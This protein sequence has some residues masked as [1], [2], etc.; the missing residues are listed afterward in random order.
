[1]NRMDDIGTDFLRETLRWLRF[2]KSL[3]DGAMAQ[4]ADEM[5]HAQPGGESNSIALIVK[6]LSGNMV[7]RWTDFL[8]A[9]GEK[10]DRNRDAEFEDDDASRTDVL[11]RWERGWASILGALEA[12]SSDDLHRTVTIRSE[13]VGVINAIQRQVTHVSYHVGQI[14]YL[15]KMLKG[16]G[17]KSLSIAR[18]QSEAYIEKMR[19]EHSGS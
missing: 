6:H 5:L 16:D 10:P 11:A 7:S 13:Q 2:E 17:W 9:D 3:G 14:V 1:M 8:T 4:I 19:R 15:S 18:G 12:L